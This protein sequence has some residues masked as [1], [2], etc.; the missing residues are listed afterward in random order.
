MASQVKPI[1][2]G[3]HRVTPYLTIKGAAKA[4]DFYKRAF[5]ATEL[6]RFE[7]DG[8]IGHAEIKIGDSPVM[9]ADEF[10][11]MGASSPQTMGGSP[12]HM[13]LYVEDVDKFVERAVGAG[14]KL[15]RPIANQFYGDR[16]GGIE[17][18]F[19]FTWYVATHIEDVPPKELQK[20]AAAA[21]AQQEQG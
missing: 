21:F 10:P 3:Y 11:N 9:L 18:P 8:K 4:I 16:M 19:G 13:M 6:M 17:D 12:I 5:G 14:A 1:P 7:H 15:Q 20:R 2:A